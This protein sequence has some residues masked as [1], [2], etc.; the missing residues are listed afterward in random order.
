M[1]RGSEQTNKWEGGRET[2][3]KET[4]VMQGEGN[5]KIIIIKML[6]GIR[7]DILTQN[8]V[9]LNKRNTERK[10]SWELKCDRRN[11]SLK[12]RL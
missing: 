2:N 5:F 6:R 7:E 4:K 9:L 1:R 8:R 11:E 12:R 3:L 10:S